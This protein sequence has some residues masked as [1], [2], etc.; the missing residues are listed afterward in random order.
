M[1]ADG[2]LERGEVRS[3]LAMHMLNVGMD[4]FF[5]EVVPAL[6]RSAFFDDRVL[7]AHQGVWP[8]GSDR[9]YS[10]LLNADAIADPFVRQFTE[11]AL[12]CPVPV[13]LGGHSLVSGGLYVL[14]E[15]AWDRSGLNIPRLVEV[16]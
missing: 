10:D 8:S 4:R 11:A 5:Q 7:W 13:V 2:R 14:V 6:G 15:A 3:L 16:G 12:A 1:R 9:F